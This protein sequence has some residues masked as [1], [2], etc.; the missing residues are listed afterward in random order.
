MK[1]SQRLDRFELR[2]SGTGGQG[3]ITLGR[4]LG[5]GLAL[6]HSYFV[7]QTQSYGPEARG[8][9]SRADL[10]VS[11]DPISYPKTEL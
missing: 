9:S 4:I 7:T 1:Q 2:A 11:S 8:G 3:I 10:V 6:G 5:Y